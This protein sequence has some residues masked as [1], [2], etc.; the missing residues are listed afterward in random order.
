MNSRL[1]DVVAVSRPA[2]ADREHDDA[3]RRV[4]QRA[5]ARAAARRGR[6]RSAGRPTSRPTAITPANASASV[7]ETTAATSPPPGRKAIAAAIAATIA[8][9]RAVVTQEAYDAAG[10]LGRRLGGGEQVGGRRVG[11]LDGAL[12]RL[13]GEAVADAEVRVDVAPVRRGLLELL[14]Q[15]AHEHVDRAV[16]AGHRVAPD[17]LVDLLALEHAPAGVGEQLDQLELAPRQVDR[18]A[19]DERLEAVGAD[20]ELAGLHGLGVLARLGAAAAAHD[21]LDA[22]DQLLGV[23]GLRQPVVGAHPQPAHALGDG[24]AAGADDDRR[25]RAARRRGARGPPRRA[26]RRPSRSTTAR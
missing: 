16:A 15:L 13:G 3:D 1:P 9:L 5:V 6:A 21:G 8:T 11:H 19:G 24:R 25:G 17:A 20:L 2:P 14:A 18:A 26:G 7:R 4:E 12:D 10:T 22:R 23:A